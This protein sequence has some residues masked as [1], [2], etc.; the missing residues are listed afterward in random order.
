MANEF[1]ARKGIISSG[2]ITLLTGSIQ[3]PGI[4]SASSITANSIEISGTET[5]I[6]TFGDSITDSHIF[7]GSI[8][9]TGSVTASF[10]KGDGSQLTNLP[11][12]AIGFNIDT[13]EFVANGSQN[14][15]NIVQSYNINS[16]IV[17]V[18]G[19]TLNPDDDYTLSTN[20]LQFVVAPPSAS[21]VLV[22]AFVNATSGVTG[23]FSGSFLGSISNAVSSSY[24]LTASYVEGASALTGGVVNYIPVWTGTSTLATSSIYQSSSRNIIIGDPQTLHPDSPPLLEVNAGVTNVKEIAH[25]HI[26]IDD[27]AELALK[28][29]SSGSN[30]SS[31]VKI[32]SD[33]GTVDDNYISIGINSSNFSDSSKI[34]DGGLN[35]FL[36]ATGSNLFIGNISAD[37]DLILF[38]GPEGSA[39][40]NARVFISAGGTVGI[41]ANEITAG[42]EES[43]FVRGLSGSVNIVTGKSSLDNY[44]QLNI[45]NENAG[46]DASSDIV[47][48]ADNGTEEVNYIDMGINGSN[49]SGLIG[50]P[51]DA[52]IYST[53]Q[54]L[55][56][57]NATATKNITIFAGGDNVTTNRKLILAANNQH[58]L[59]GSLQVSGSVTASFSGSLTGTATSASYVLPSGLPAGTVSA[60]SQVNG[61][62]IT[63]NSVS[64]T[65]GTG[66][67]GG[68]SATLGGGAVTINAVAGNGISV[69]APTNDAINVDTGSVHF[70]GGVTTR[71]NALGVF[72]SSAQVSY[73]G[74]SNIPSGIVSSS[75]Q[76][77]SL[78]PSGVVSASSQIN[79]GSFSGSFNG[80]FTG[81]FSGSGTNL[82]MAFFP[83]VISGSTGWTQAFNGTITLPTVKVALYDNANFEGPLRVYTVAG[84]TS[85][86]GGIPA[87]TNNTTNYIFIKYNNGSPVYD[88]ALNNADINNSSAVLFMIV[89]R[90]DTFIHT[91]EFGNYGAGLATKTSERIINTDRFARES[92][93]N[94]S[95]NTGS[96][97]LAISSGVAW[98]GP[99][100]QVLAAIDSNDIFFEVYHSG[101]NWTSS[102]SVGGAAPGNNTINN[103]FYD[104]GTDRIAVGTGKY[105]TNWY[106]RGQEV[107]DHIYEVFSQNEYDTVAEAQLATLPSLPELVSSHGFLVGRI[108]VQSGS[109]NGIVE[110]SFGQ[111]FQ[112]T[113]VDAHND[114]TGI[115]GGT[116]G[117]YYHL[118]QNEYD[119]IALENT[120]VTFTTV[121]SSFSGSL[122]GTASFANTASFALAVAGG[123]VTSITAGNGLAGGTITSTGTISLDTGSGHFVSGSRKTI[124]AANTTGASGI[125]TTY[126]N[127]TG[128]FSSS[129]VNSSVTVNGQSVS[130]GGSTTVTANTTNTLTLGNGL[131]GTS[132]NGSTAITT[133]VDTGSAHFTNGVTTRLNALGVFS[134]SAQVSYTSISNRPSGIVS[135][136]AQIVSGIAGQNI[137]PTILSASIVSASQ[138]TGSLKQ[139]S[140]GTTA[141]SNPAVNDLWVDTN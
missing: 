77:T 116:G 52:Y 78:L 15:F 131:T 31:V 23:S 57:G 134:S 97:V 30:A 65:A 83:G 47:A 137:S 21:T 16:L 109:F 1:I 60:S 40:D 20:N 118:T 58:K 92:G 62:N 67:S 61:A 64:Y 133:N 74:L 29:Y 25:F 49:F 114:L 41:N 26:D 124:S 63:N 100:R 9:V 120:S 43:L 113:T 94:L 102:V 101:G 91:L 105:L 89:Y 107:N 98:N 80:A 22:R 76:V 70:T 125:N 108:I 117:Q 19:L 38:N 93:L 3:T 17:T 2:S 55:Y 10:F 8:S 73:T 72:S 88:V 51:N 99:N 45:Q 7:T 111:I 104:N 13:Y 44:I 27:G 28:N 46:T 4:V 66:L 106:Y 32:I 79:T 48:T 127:L 14:S 132:F 122:L 139:L 84:G 123:G 68:G 96:G 39:L 53:G 24:A 56:I 85:G 119:N 33:A 18:D 126:N 115:Q 103:A 128:I 130:L 141:P 86:T 34:V 95:V 12:S 54:E 37:K 11:A 136:S 87:L 42:N 82:E 135:S 59:S 71:I 50:G 121:T 140:V 35:A 81:S 5:N 129:L 138:I 6:N 110:S 69:T 36:V 90:L 112:A 75:A